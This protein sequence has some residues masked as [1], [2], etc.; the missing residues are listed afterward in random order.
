MHSR[1]LS[2]LNSLWQ[3][4]NQML[5]TFFRGSGSCWQTVAQLLQISCLNI[6]DADLLFHRIQYIIHSIKI[7]WLWRPLDSRL[8]ET[9]LRL[10][11]LWWSNVLEVDNRRYGHTGVGMVRKGYLNNVQLLLRGPN[12]TPLHYHLNH[13]PL[14]L[15]CFFCLFFYSKFCRNI[16]VET[17]MF[18][19][20]LSWFEGSMYIIDPVTVF[21]CQECELL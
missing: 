4:F 9:C 21:V 12:P 2:E 19:L 18:S 1:L 5:A 20:L 15:S 3:R 10:F 14:L 13:E 6:H 8:W 16:A 7:W 17:Q 11:E